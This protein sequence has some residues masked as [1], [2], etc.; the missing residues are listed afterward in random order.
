MKLTNKIATIKPPQGV[1]GQA[2]DNRVLT[3]IAQKFLPPGAKLLKPCL[4]HRQGG[5]C[6][7]TGHGQRTNRAGQSPKTCAESSGTG[8][9][10]CHG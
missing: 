7:Q 10:D 9:D 6:G 4:E 8:L 3:S 1:G 2:K 5:G